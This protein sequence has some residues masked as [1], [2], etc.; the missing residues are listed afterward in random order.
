MN[1]ISRFLPKQEFSSYEDFSENFTL[2]LPDKFNFAF[3][4]VDFY[5][6]HAPDQRALVWCNDEGST[7]TFSFKDISDN[8]KLAADYLLKKGICKGDIVM[9]A[10]H[11]RYEYWIFIVALHRLGAVALPVSSQLTDFLRVM[12]SSLLMK[13][14]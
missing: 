8:S 13:N 2:E 3:D 6:E 10:L 7:K 9:L 11:R 12:Q 14:L 1:L 5:A 4:V